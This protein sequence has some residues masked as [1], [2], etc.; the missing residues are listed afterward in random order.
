MKKY[1]FLKDTK[2]C[3]MSFMGFKI[4][5]PDSCINRIQIKF[6]TPVFEFKKNKINLVEMEFTKHSINR[7]QEILD[8]IKEHVTI[9]KQRLHNCINADSF[10]F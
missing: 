5:A 4:Y 7:D 8:F 9:E 2:I 10:R 3:S 1:Q 6:D